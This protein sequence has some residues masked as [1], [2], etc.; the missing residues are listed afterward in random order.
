[1][2]DEVRQKRRRSLC[3][4]FPRFIFLGNKLRLAAMAMNKTDEP[5]QQKAKAEEGLQ[6]EED[7]VSGRQNHEQDFGLE[8]KEN[9]RPAKKSD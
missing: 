1:M 9:A 3:V 5:E 6:K 8:K 4:L 7:D 2:D